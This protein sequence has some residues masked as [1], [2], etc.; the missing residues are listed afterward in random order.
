MF[1]TIL[2]ATDHAVDRNV[3]HITNFHFSNTYNCVCFF[4]SFYKFALDIMLKIPFEVIFGA[5]T[6]T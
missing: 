3:D 6:S 4:C 5:N 1:M 2:T